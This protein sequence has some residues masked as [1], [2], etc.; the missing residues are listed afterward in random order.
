MF[1]RLLNSIR[2]SYKTINEL[3][4]SVNALENQVLVLKQELTEL[5]N[6]A[7][8]SNRTI[9]DLHEPIEFTDLSDKTIK[10]NELYNINDVYKELEGKAPHSF[11]IYMKLMK[12][13][14]DEYEKEDSA[15]LAVEESV[16]G[17]CFSKFIK[18]YLYGNVLDVGCGPQEIP[19][20][21]NKYPVKNIYGLDPLLPHKSH[22][23]SFAQGVAESIPWEDESFN[24]VIFATSFDHV[25]L[26][27]KVIDEVKRVLCNNGYLLMWVSFDENAKDYNPYASDFEPYDKY[28]MFH[29][30]KKNYE[31]LMNKHFEI[32]EYYKSHYNNHFY[33]MRKK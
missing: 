19:I 3:A 29:N 5:K 30:T 10:K 16:E 15:S 27:D 23:F 7:E 22:P 8:C 18:R 21:L 12:T 17:N 14:T 28:H 20:Y 1:F 25:F 9:L 32:V 2:R 6:I 33:A 24:V 13:G 31:E 26:V 4:N 11:K